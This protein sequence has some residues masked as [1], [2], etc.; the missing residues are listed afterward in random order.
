MTDGVYCDEAVGEKEIGREVK[1]GRKTE[2]EWIE[3]QIGGCGGEEGMALE[4]KEKQVAE[5]LMVEKVEDQVVEM[6]KR[7]AVTGGTERRYPHD[8][9]YLQETGGADSISAY[10]WEDSCPVQK[11]GPAEGYQPRHKQSSQHPSSML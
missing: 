2:V 6:V 7:L 4:R 10:Q 11:P 8:S 9:I 3:A 1:R 5:G